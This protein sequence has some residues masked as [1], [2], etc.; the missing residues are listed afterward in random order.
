MPMHT[1]DFGNMSTGMLGGNMNGMQEGNMRY[2]GMDIGAYLGPESFKAINEIIMQAMARIPSG[3]IPAGGQE[4]S[5]TVVLHPSGTGT[6]WIMSP[7]PYK[8]WRW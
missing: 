1:N 4:W 7:N 5:A 3:Q 8:T 6:A 2:E